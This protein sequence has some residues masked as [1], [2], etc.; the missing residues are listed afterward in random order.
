MDDS[1]RIWKYIRKCLRKCK[2]LSEDNPHYCEMKM[3]EDVLMKGYLSSEDSN[4][5]I[6]VMLGESAAGDGAASAR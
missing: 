3:H 1:W 5:F 6:K 4:K 2:K